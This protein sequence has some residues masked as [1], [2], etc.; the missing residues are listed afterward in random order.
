MRFHFQKTS[1]LIAILSLFLTF[2]EGQVN[3]T[4]GSAVFTLP[5]FNWSEEKSGLGVNVEINYSS[6]TGLR[7][8]DLASDIGQG[9]DLEAG[10]FITRMQVGLPDDQKPREGNGTIEDITKYPPGYLYDPKNPTDGCPVGL[11]KYPIFKDKNHLYQQ[12]NVV[13]ADK[14]L[15]Y[16]AFQLNGRRGVFVLSTASPGKCS[17]LGSTMMKGWY[18]RNENAS[19]DGYRTTITSFYFKDEF[20][21]TYKFDHKERTKV[22][23][24]NFCDAKFTTP[25]NQPKFKDHKVYNEGSFENNSIVNPYIVTGWYL[26]EIRDSMANRVTTFE[27]ETINI[28]SYAGAG[29]AHYM[30]DNYSIISHVKSKTETPRLKAINMPDGHRVVFNYGSGRIDLNGAKILASIDVKYGTRFVSKYILNSTYVIKNRYGMPNTDFQ[31]SHARLYLRSVKKIGPD[32]KAE[33]HPY[34]FDYYLGSD[35]PDDFV[36]PPFFHFKD[37]WGYYN[38]D[39]SKSVNGSNIPLEKPLVELS[40]EEVKG[41]CFIRNGQQGTVINP[42]AGYAKNGLLKQILYPEGSAITYE[43]QQNRGLL[44]GSETNVGGVHVSKTIK[45]DGGFSNGCDNPIVEN[46]KFTLPDGLSSSL[47]GIESPV[48][49]NTVS[50][51]Y[52]PE[53]KYFYFRPILS[54]GCDYRIQHPG[55]MSR[56]QAVSL[57]SMQQ[58]MNT[59]SKIMDVVGGVMTIVDIVKLSLSA[60][61]ANILA[62]VIDVVTTIAVVAVT[63][64]LDPTKE[65]TK[66]VYYNSA[67]NLTNPLP[68]QFKRVEIIEGAGGKGKTAIDYTSSEDYAI[69]QPTNP[70]FSMK[71]RFAPWAYGLPKNTTSYDANGQKV[72]ETINTYNFNDAAT[73]LDQKFQSHYSVKCLVKKSSSQRFDQWSDPLV[74]NGTNS[75]ITQSSSDMDVDLYWMLSGHV[76]LFNAEERIYK[77]GDQSKFLS[78]VT[79]FDYANLKV[80][81]KSTTD[82]D[83]RIIQNHYTYSGEKYGEPLYNSMI[84]NNMLWLPV[85]TSTTIYDPVTNQSTFVDKIKTDYAVAPNGEIKPVK[86]YE[87]LNATSERV[88]KEMSYDVD[89]NLIKVK[90]EGGRLLSN[91]YDYDGKYITATVVNA[92]LVHDRV[93]FCGFET[94]SLGG[95]VLNGSPSYSL[96]S[97]VTG[98]RSLTL[99]GGG[100]LQSYLNTKKAYK[101][102]FWASGSVI[103]SAGGISKSGPTLNGFTFFEYSIP[104][105]NS[106]VVVSGTGLIDELRLLPSDARMTTVAY[107]PVI[108][109]IS[110]CDDANRITYYEYDRLGRLEIVRD[111]KMNIL[112]TIEY[113]DVERTSAC[114]VVYTNKWTYELFFKNDCPEGFF[115][116]PV[117]YTVPAGKYSSM[118]SQEAADAEAQFELDQLGQ[119]HANTNG[120]CMTIYKS[121]QKTATFYKQGCPVGYVGGAFTYTVPQ[122]KYASLHSQEAADEMAQDELDANGQAAANM[123]G[124][125]TC[126]ISTTPVWEGTGLEDCVNGSKMMQVKDMN[127]NSSTYNQTQWVNFAE[128]QSCPPPVASCVY[129]RI[130]IPYDVMPDLYI[131]YIPCDQ[132][133]PEMKNVLND[134]LIIDYGYAGVIYICSKTPP[135]FRY[136]Y[137]GP[138][139]DYSAS[140]IEVHEE[141]YCN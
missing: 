69:W 121:A 54:M 59:F 95:W 11:T 28:D 60:T 5:I 99:P 101:L 31:R 52:S 42:K 64:F 76:Q 29:I 74:Y 7:V 123:P 91:I 55:I 4:T 141:R 82:S 89:G 103:V 3:H 117:F 88:T 80:R 66:T 126:I 9:W 50:S 33:E 40:N 2:A 37:N 8:N 83:G 19:N 20:G 24:Y 96:T 62:V 15:D 137:W 127:P 38:G 22:M 6:G 75:H 79:T 34:Y 105:G 56:D 110:E 108:G 98:K 102:S 114:P 47:W 30:E 14:E 125:S 107:D 136:N 27:Y 61:P 35:N 115:G 48:H 68:S 106:R 53:D 93:A 129:Y 12:H 13:G 109:K 100:N 36:P 70:T 84:D 43:Y 111:E 138:I 120:T 65:S 85:E 32:L 77:P 67:I 16:F 26:S 130:A 78:S 63:C 140:D 90:D 25:L 10:G 133:L 72:K 18:T 118:V 97:F 57:T 135:V 23:K 113:N 128:D 51:Y 87:S 21:I 112:K 44:N 122:G 71:Q 73:L 124:A 132:M 41:L 81:R 86:I 94:T 119:N 1:F 116:S 17:F 39:Q 45:T 139:I 58:F 104:A 134:M 46:Y 131:E 49:N 92:D